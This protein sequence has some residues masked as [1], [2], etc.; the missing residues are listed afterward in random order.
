M[1]HDSFL[2]YQKGERAHMNQNSSAFA[3]EPGSADPHSSHHGA[4]S[5]DETLRL[6]LALSARMANIVYT[7][8][9]Q[10]SY[11]CAANARKSAE[12]SIASIEA[13]WPASPVRE[14]LLNTYR[15]QAQSAELLEHELLAGAR[16][17]CGL[18][19]AQY[20]YGRR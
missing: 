18:A 9:V 14:L 10:M 15:A 16:R 7:A 2:H 11:A 19:Y 6:P 17:R 5:A 8:Q 13:T 4:A 20:G 1:Q 3:T 12:R